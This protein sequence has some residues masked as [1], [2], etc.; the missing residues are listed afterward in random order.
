M[1]R[2]YLRLQLFSDSAG[3]MTTGVPVEIGG[4]PVLLWAKLRLLFSDGDGLRMGL[5][6]N[7]A[8]SV[9]PCFRHWNVLRAGDD[10]ISHCAGYVV[11]S[12]HDASKFL[13]LIHI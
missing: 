12:E 9:K 3:L 10:R 11:I 1:L 4:V 2:D 7:G 8:A 6:W 5:A 13:S